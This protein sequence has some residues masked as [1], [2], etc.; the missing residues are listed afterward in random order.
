MTNRNSIN[1][2]ESFN[3]IIHHFFSCNFGRKKSVIIISN[4]VYI[5]LQKSGC[6]SRLIFYAEFNRFQFIV[7][8]FLAGCHTMG[9]QP[10]LSYYFKCQQIQGAA[11]F[12]YEGNHCNT[13]V[14]IF[15]TVYDSLDCFAVHRLPPYLLFCCFASHLCVLSSL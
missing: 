15:P 11:C 8:L 7:F 3:E 13:G 14:S 5:Y 1:Y 4:C 12:S 9:K 2:F 6:K 10:S